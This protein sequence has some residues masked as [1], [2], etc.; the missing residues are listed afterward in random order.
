MERKLTPPKRHASTD[1]SE[2]PL[3]VKE[4]LQIILINPLTHTQIHTP[5]GGTRTPPQRF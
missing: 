2:K 3:T 5:S 1:E 4:Y